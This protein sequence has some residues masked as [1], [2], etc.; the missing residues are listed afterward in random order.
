MATYQD[1]RDSIARVVGGTAPDVVNRPRWYS[2]SEVGDG[3]GVAGMIGCYSAA[4]AALSA[5]G[6]GPVGGAVGMVLNGPGNLHF[7]ASADSLGPSQK[8][9]F[10]NPRLLILIS[11]GDP[12]TEDAL[13]TP[14]VDLIPAAFEAHT[15]LFNA[16]NVN[17]VAANTWRFIALTYGTDK[18]I[19]W[20]FTLRV[21]R[22]SNVTYR[23]G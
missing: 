20:D 16:P 13:I 17:Q 21:F 6:S 4:Q 11:R 2:G 5:A 8:Y 18:F 3:T 1:L 12:E 23:L 14:F 19:G 9:Q 10:D 22:T 15:T 7:P